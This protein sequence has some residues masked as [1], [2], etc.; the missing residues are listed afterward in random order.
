MADNIH[1]ANI[2]DDL[3]KRAKKKAKA[4]GKTIDDVLTDALRHYTSQRAIPITEDAAAL[5][6]NLAADR[7]AGSVFPPK[8]A[9]LR[10]FLPAG[11]GM[12]LFDS[13]EVS[14]LLRGIGSSLRAPMYRGV[15][16]DLEQLA[17]ALDV[18]ALQ[19]LDD[20]QNGP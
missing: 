9:T 4:E 14:G 3:W 5:M 8:T 13:G 19:A 18:Q 10:T 17:D 7:P 15:A 1:K 2:N 11:S 20:L 16:Q 6:R 12:V